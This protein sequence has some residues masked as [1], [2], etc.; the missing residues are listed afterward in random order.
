MKK[1]ITLLPALALMLAITACSGGGNRG[2]DTAPQVTNIRFEIEDNIYGENQ[3][4]LKWDEPDSTN[5]S[6]YLVSYSSDG[7]TWIDDLTVPANHDHSYLRVMV[8]ALEY[9]SRS[10]L[11]N[12]TYQVRITSIGRNGYLSSAPAVSDKTFTLTQ[13]TSS[14]P[15]LSAKKDIV[16]TQ[17][18]IDGTFVSGTRYIVDNGTTFTN[19]I[20]YSANNI[21]WAW[22]DFTTP[23]NVRSFE[24]ACTN[25]SATIMLSASQNPPVTDSA[26]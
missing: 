19:L 6:G 21:T 20:A 26:R 22:S 10:G 8:G 15:V 1:L 12:G 18:S 9:W 3:L 4:C 5:I 24:T 11:E 23:I 25:G 7:I 13:G 14:V 2:N 17:I 16:P